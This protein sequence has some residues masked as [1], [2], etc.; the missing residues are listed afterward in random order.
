MVKLADRIT[1][2]EPPPPDWDL[3]DR[4]RY[5]QE[6]REILKALG[7]ASPE[8]WARFKAKV[9]EYEAYCRAGPAPMNDR[10]D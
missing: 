5:L 10:R 6:A 3:P 4:Q 8:P 2:L 9:V 1:N 7:S